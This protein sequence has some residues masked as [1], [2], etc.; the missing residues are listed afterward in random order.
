MKNK[1][2]AILYISYDGM[3]EP[4]GQS[5][6]LSYLKQLSS[7][8][9]IY[10]ISFEKKND[11]SNSNERDKLDSVIRSFGITWHPLRYHKKFS[12]L[13]TAFDVFI[14]TLLGGYLAHTKKIRVIHARSYVAAIP[15][16]IIKFILGTKFIFDMRGFWVDERVDGGIWRK[17]S[18]IYKIG[19]WFEKKF[20]LNADHVVTLTK[21]SVVEIEKFPYLKNR[22]PQITIIPTC[23]DLTRFTLNRSQTKQK[24]F[25][26]GYVGS[27]GTWYMFDEVVLCFLRLLIIKPDARFLILNKGDHEFIRSKLLAA[28]IPETHFEIKSAVHSE[29]HTEISKMSMSIFFIKPVFSKKGSAPTKL[30]EF[31]GAGVPCL[32]NTGV[33][34]M[35]D[36]LTNQSIGVVLNSFDQRA[37]DFGIYQILDL[38][39]DEQL[40]CRCNKVANDNF[41]LD[42]GVR[43]YSNIYNK[44]MVT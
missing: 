30:A 35:D 7:D 9:D 40:G 10:I 39:K 25:I 42:E 44:L 33:G 5:Q 27:V 11:W 31:L 28:Q 38:L 23:A 26:C 8:W 16:L 3:L 37:M 13:S 12:V 24:D 29:I 36:I 43:R 17:E 6:V 1:R 32:S 41:S 15:A 14:A 2:E 4:L 34:D 22:I 21:A 20:L 18:L 19:K